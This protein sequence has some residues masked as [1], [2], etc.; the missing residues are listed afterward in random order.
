MK[1]AA[2]V[3]VPIAI[4]LALWAVFGSF[5]PREA[6]PDAPPESVPDEPRPLAVPALRP[7]DPSTEKPSPAAPEGEWTLHLL[8]RNE[9]GEPMHGARIWFLGAHPLEARTGADG[10]T[11]LKLTGSGDLAVRHSMGEPVRI[12]GLSPPESGEEHRVVTL[13]IGHE[14]SGVVLDPEGNP[15]DRTSHTWLAAT[16]IETV[17]WCAEPDSRVFTARTGEDGCFRFRFL[18]PGEYRVRVLS[19]RGSVCAVPREQVPAR[20]DDRE[21]AVRLVGARTV[22]LRLIDAATG[23]PVTSL[24]EIGMEDREGGWISGR[25][26]GVLTLGNVPADEVRLKVAVEGYEAALVILTP[27]METVDVSLNRGG[28]HLVLEVSDA[29]GLAVEAIRLTRAA[30]ARGITVNMREEHES[31]GGRYEIPL[32]P[33]RHRLRVED[34]A[35]C[36]VGTWIDIEVKAGERPVRRVVLAGGGTIRIPAEDLVVPQPD[37]VR[38]AGGTLSRAVMVCREDGE[39]IP[40]LK[41]IRTAED[42]LLIPRLPAGVLIVKWRDREGKPAE[43]RV[44]IVAGE[45]TEVRLD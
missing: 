32:S 43:K 37:D 15:V 38:E 41:R 11:D 20:T 31:P 23:D 40:A 30:N 6:P 25:H 39:R 42:D 16:P 12:D 5:G 45:T 3:A 24:T 13:G 9:S 2:L 4:A 21:V 1:R 22:V 33:G 29:T 19:V 17:P 35:Q 34:G 36:L 28:A 27:E 26:D 18:P 8:V 14:I 10:H 7:T 44:T